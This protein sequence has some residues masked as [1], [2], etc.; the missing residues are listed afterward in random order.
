VAC[1]YEKRRHSQDDE[2]C[3]Q[4]RVGTNPAKRYPT[5]RPI[6]ASAAEKENSKMTV[7][8]RQ[9]APGAAQK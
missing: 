8:D 6:S 3:N 9:A 2:V 5:L 7:A 4:R 1:I